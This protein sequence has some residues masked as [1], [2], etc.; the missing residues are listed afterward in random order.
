MT[1]LMSAIG[2]KA[3]IDKTAAAMSPNDPKRTSTLPVRS[4]DPVLGHYDAVSETWGKH[5]AAGIYRGTRW[6]GGDAAGRACA[7][8]DAGHRVYR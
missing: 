6:R 7:A 1:R 4:I 2:G 5:E 3:D 8:G